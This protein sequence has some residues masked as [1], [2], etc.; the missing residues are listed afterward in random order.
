MTPRGCV[1]VCF[2]VGRESFEFPKRYYSVV[3][4]RDETTEVSNRKWYGEKLGF[5]R[6]KGSTI[7]E[8]YWLVGQKCALCLLSKIH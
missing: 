6:T 3:K 5:E 8:I 4:M 1:C 2:C 7:I